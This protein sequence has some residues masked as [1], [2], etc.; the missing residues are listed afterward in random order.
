MGM[1][2]KAH[3]HDPFWGVTLYYFP[4]VCMFECI[5]NQTLKNLHNIFAYYVR[6]QYRQDIKNFIL[7][8]FIKWEIGVYL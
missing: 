5:S 4:K 8:H 7:F 3:Y 6:I 1:G 2:V